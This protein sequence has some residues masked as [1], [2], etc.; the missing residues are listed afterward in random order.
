[1]KRTFKFY[2]IMVVAVFSAMVMSACSDDSDDNELQVSASAEMMIPSSVI[3]G[4][5]VNNIDGLVNIGYNADGTIDEATYNGVT[6]DFQYENNSRAISTGKRLVQVIARYTDPDDNSYNSWNATNFQFNSDG[7]V[8]SYLEKTIS[9]GNY[10]GINCEDETTLN[11]SLAYNAKGRLDFVDVFGSSK[12]FDEE[13]S[14]NE[15]GSF[16]IHY[17]YNGGSFEKSEFETD[18]TRYTCSYEYDH[19]HSNYYNVVTPELAMGMAQYSPI[20]LIL[21]FS[22]YLGNSS[23][24]LPT[25]FIS[26][27]DDFEEGYKYD[28]IYELSYKFDDKNRITEIERVCDG[29]PVRWEFRYSQGINVYRNLQ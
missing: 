24:Q 13:G 2:G 3:D 17:K 29:F 26:S 15:R 23:S 4:V 6:Y 20:T 16:T 10:M 14:Y 25:R 27:Y 19:P 21:A 5:R 8:Q 28:D 11:V 12:G 22:G 1:M 9:R 18:G 7:F